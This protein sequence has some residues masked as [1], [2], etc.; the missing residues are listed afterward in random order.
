MS[1]IET[2]EIPAKAQQDHNW[3]VDQNLARLRENVKATSNETRA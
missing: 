1:K 2:L 3:K